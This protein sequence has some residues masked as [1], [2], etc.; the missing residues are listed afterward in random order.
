ML[1]ILYT[2]KYLITHKLLQYFACGSLGVPTTWFVVAHYVRRMSDDACSSILNA[3]S[4]A[5]NDFYSL[6]FF[7]ERETQNLIRKTFFLFRRH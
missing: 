3:L 7:F 1:Y 6:F 5:L 2:D 4:I